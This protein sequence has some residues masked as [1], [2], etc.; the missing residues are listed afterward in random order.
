M[1]L[2]SL[3]ATCAQAVR[4]EHMDTDDLWELQAGWPSPALPQLASHVLA[5]RAGLGRAAWSVP[6]RTR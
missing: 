4:V 2:I 1:V 3:L 6:K 5:K